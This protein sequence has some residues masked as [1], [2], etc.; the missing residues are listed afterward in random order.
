MYFTMYV[1]KVIT[2]DSI[3]RNIFYRVPKRQMILKATH[4]TVHHFPF[5][6]I[7]LTSQPPPHPPQTSTT[8]LTPTDTQSRPYSLS[9]RPPL[10][11]QA[12]TDT[13]KR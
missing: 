4:P 9:P 12:Y 7:V 1:S 8:S 3:T 13:V 11:N 10:P 6:N 2:N 5:K